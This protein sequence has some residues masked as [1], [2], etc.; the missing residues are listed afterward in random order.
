MQKQV[1]LGQVWF[2][3]RWPGDGV[4]DLFISMAGKVPAFGS[5]WKELERGG[6][7]S[8]AYKCVQFLQD[9]QGGGSQKP[10]RQIPFC[11][12]RH[13]SLCFQEAVGLRR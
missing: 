9:F 6:F 8:K 3:T 2:Q 11:W 1:L 13:S 7:M 5:S 10:L 12:Q 4:C